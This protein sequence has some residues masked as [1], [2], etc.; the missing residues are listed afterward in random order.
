MQSPSEACITRSRHNWYAREA[1]VKDARALLRP[2]G[3]PRRLIGGACS[4]TATRVTSPTWYKR[5]KRESKRRT[6]ARGRLLR[7]P[8]LDAQ[9]IAAVTALRIHCLRCAARPEGGRPPATGHFSSTAFR[10]PQHQQPFARRTGC[11]D[12]GFWYVKRVLARRLAVRPRRAAARRDGARRACA[13]A[14]RVFLSVW[15]APRNM[16]PRNMD[17]HNYYFAAAFSLSFAEAPP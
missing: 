8:R 4:A 1:L 5:T 16:D 9:P 12:V 17:P 14:R 13:R 15:P 11:E 10:P 6:S 7:V 2:S 3:P